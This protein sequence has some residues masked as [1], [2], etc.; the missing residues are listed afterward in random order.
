[1][2]ERIRELLDALAITQQQLADLAVVSKAAVNAWMKKGTKP[3]GDAL[4]N[5]RRKRGINPDW[6]IDGEGNMFLS[7]SEWGTPKSLQNSYKP[8][9]VV[10][11]AQLGPN[12]YWEAMEYPVGHGDG[13]ISVPSS[14]PNAYALRVRG[15][16]M[17]PAIRDGWF[18]VVEPHN[19][20]A[21]GEYVL[22]VTTDG[23]AMIKELLWERGDQIALMSVNEDF[24]RLTLTRDRIEKIHH[25]A[26]IAPPSKHLL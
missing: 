11:T 1:M 2:P 17:A 18:V 26:F 9:P 12:G 5:M 24:G 19:S 21:P 4:L 3:S 15:D 22:I 6:I 25:V 16:S 20:V 10:G 8:A 14:D 7:N 13:F 23:Q